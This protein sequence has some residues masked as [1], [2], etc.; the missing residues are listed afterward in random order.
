MS[1][2][3]QSVLIEWVKEE[4]RLIGG[5]EDDREIA[6]NSVP[7]QAPDKVKEDHS[8]RLGGAQSST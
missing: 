6:P 8:V 4:Q 7:T 1:R 3:G 5:Y 2:I